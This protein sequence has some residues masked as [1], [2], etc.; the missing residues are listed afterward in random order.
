MRP[1]VARLRRGPGLP[2]HSLEVFSASILSEFDMRELPDKADLAI[3]TLGEATL[4]PPPAVKREGF[5]TAANDVLVAQDVGQQQ[6]FLDRGEAPPFFEAAG[7]RAKIFFAPERV[8]CGI[9]TCGGVCPGLNDVV[10]SIVLTLNH[11]YGV[12]RILGFRYGYLGLSPESPCPPV[13]LT[14]EMVENIHQ[15]GGTMLGTSRGPR[16]LG[17]MADRL[18]ELDLQVLFTIGGDGTLRGASALAAEIA[19]RGLAISVVGVPKTIDNDLQWTQQSFGFA[20][21]VEEARAAVVAAHNEARAALNGVGLVKLMGR[22]SGSIAAHAALADA[23]V[24]FCLIPEAPFTLEGRGGFLELL[25]ARIADRRHAVVVVAEGAG[26]ELIASRSEVLDASGN[27]LLNDVGVF[28]RRRIREHF[29]A[30]GIPIEVKYIDPSY[31]IRSRAANSFDSRFC[32][33]LGQHAVHAAMAGRTDM[34][35]GFWNHRFTHVPIALAASERKRVDPDGEI[36]QRVLA[37]TGQPSSMM[38]T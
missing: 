15:Q 13:A 3:R 20:T 32:L 11:A 10:R 16:D 19:R 30:R 21:A 27:L 2:F 26:Q 9:V 35:V 37:S 5:V 14:P 8:G 31:T 36:W 6:P 28:L 23:D 7:P 33:I 25:Q 17:R 38:G 18:V 1:F 24:N 4:P 22:A 29:S 34:V 12:R